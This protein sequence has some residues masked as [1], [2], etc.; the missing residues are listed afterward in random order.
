MQV[1]FLNR[2][3]SECSES[4]GIEFSAQFA[5]KSRDSSSASARSHLRFALPNAVNIV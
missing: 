1:F 4:F 3:S 5:R 2:I